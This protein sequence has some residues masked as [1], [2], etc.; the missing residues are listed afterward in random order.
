M[1]L[2]GLGDDTVGGEDGS[3]ARHALAHA[4]DP[5]ERNASVVARVEFRNDFSLEQ[6]IKSFGFRRVPTGIIAM[7]APIADGPADFLRIR[8][9]PP[10]VQLATVEAAIDDPFPP[11]RAAGLH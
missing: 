10:A 2:G 1:F 8:C 9:R 6:C 11:P 7:L 5:T 4:A 3:Q